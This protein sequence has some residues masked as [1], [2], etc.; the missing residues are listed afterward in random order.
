MCLSVCVL[1]CVSQIVPRNYFNKSIGTFIK[2][3][4]R[5]N[6]TS[7]GGKLLYSFAILLKNLHFFTIGTSGV[8]YSTGE[9]YFLPPRG[10]IPP[11]AN[12][13]FP[14]LTNGF[15]S[16]CQFHLIRI[17]SCFGFLIKLKCLTCSID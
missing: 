13:L 3:I 7:H 12:C 5:N 1:P 4:P 10:A 15:L 9:L 11:G 14:A 16:L 17:E 2:I 6:L 8:F